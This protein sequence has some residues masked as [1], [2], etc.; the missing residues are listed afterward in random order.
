MGKERLTKL[1]LI[2]IE[3]ELVLSLDLDKVV[4]KFA[5]APLQSQSHDGFSDSRRL[6]LM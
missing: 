1:A 2:S 6:P 3:K 4:D 5:T